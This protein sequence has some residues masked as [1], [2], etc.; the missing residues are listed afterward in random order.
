[1]QSPRTAAFPAMPASL[2]PTT[3]DIVADLER[4][5]PLLADLLSGVSLSSQPDQADSLNA[6]LE[7][8]R[9]RREIDFTNYN[10]PTILRRL[11]RRLAATRMPT[12]THCMRHLAGNAD[13]YQR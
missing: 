6:L 10:R 4:I 12:L 11:Q 5:V 13:E 2:A 9:A 7:Q 1:M 8:V 3:V